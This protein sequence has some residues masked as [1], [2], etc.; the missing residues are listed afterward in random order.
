M[1]NA[2]KASWLH[3]SQIQCNLIDGRERIMQ[4]AYSTQEYALAALENLRNEAKKRGDKKSVYYYCV[5]NLV[6]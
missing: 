1:H 5:L 3:T 2:A 4:S 6:K